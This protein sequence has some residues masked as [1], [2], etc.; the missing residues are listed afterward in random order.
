MRDGN[1]LNGGH[2]LS[3]HQGERKARKQESPNA[4]VVA[5]PAVRS[6]ANCFDGSLHFICKARCESLDFAQGTGKMLRRT[7]RLRLRGIRQVYLSCESF[8]EIL[9]CTSSHGIVCAFPESRSAIRREISRSHAS[10]AA[11]SSSASR[12]SINE[13]ASFARS[14]S[15]SV[16]AFC[17]SSKAS[18]VMTALYAA[19]WSA[20]ALPLFWQRN[21]DP[22]S[23][24]STGFSLCGTLSAS[25]GLLG[26]LF[27]SPC[28]MLFLL[29]LCLP[30]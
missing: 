15:E 19:V 27:S 23:G 30:T 18:F 17:S 9:R 7:L 5:R 25:C 21:P 3:I 28:A 14:S 6:H 10:L 16:S 2:K 12:L 24:C 1:H 8:A 4:F 20:G 29:P 22:G 11:L 13:P 26:S